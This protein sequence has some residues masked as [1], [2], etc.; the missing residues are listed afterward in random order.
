MEA[1]VAYANS[2]ERAEEL[3]RFKKKLKKSKG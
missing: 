1:R 3:A 2:K